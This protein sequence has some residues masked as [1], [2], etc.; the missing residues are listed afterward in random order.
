MQNDTWWGRERF[1]TLRYH[2]FDVFK[3]FFRLI[4]IRPAC[5]LVYFVIMHALALALA[6]AHAHA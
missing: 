1:T 6:H 4:L 2:K 3:Y 5:V